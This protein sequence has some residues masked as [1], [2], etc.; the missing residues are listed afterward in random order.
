M[1]SGTHSEF[2]ARPQFTPVDHAFPLACEREK[3]NN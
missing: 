3:S 2:R 1:E